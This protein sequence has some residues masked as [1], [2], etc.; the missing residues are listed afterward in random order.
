MARDESIAFSRNLVQSFI[1][2]KM[3]QL[4]E[5]RD[6]RY[7]EQLQQ[8]QRQF[9][10]TLG[11]R[12]KEAEARIKYY[13][14]G[15][16]RSNI[17]VFSPGQISG[18]SQTQGIDDIIAEEIGNIPIDKSGRGLFTRARSETDRIK[19]SDIETARRNAMSRLGIQYLGVGKNQQF[20]FLFNR[21]LETLSSPESGRNVEIIQPTF[22]S[23]QPEQTGIE[24]TAPRSFPGAGAGMTFPFTPTPKTEPSNFSSERV[25]VISPDGKRGNIP[26]S[27]LQSA[28]E[29]GYTQP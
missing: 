9:Q 20:D 2:A 23:N 12:R 25:E 1:Q 14:R 10:Q 13:E 19:A 17:T 28:L 27:Q 18:T 8:N 15:G 29:S 21:Q 7:S 6:R 26:R 16:A 3:L 24:D 22:P 11:V 5:R 4:Q